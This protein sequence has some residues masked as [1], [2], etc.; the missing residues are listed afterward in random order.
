M[1]NICY[2]LDLLSWVVDERVSIQRSAGSHKSDYLAI[3][4]SHFENKM[5]ISV[6]SN[7]K[8]KKLPLAP[9]RFRHISSYRSSLRSLR[10]VGR[11][12][13]AWGRFSRRHRPIGQAKVG[14]AS[15][16][17]TSSSSY[18]REQSPEI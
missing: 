13:A 11:I 16:T 18:P 2:L 7:H 15:M 9:K 10:C 1:S 5:D 6:F 14:N 12:R 3:Y 8:P 17:E 4:R